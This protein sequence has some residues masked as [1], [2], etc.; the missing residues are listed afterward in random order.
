MPR[1]EGYVVWELGLESLSHV[2]WHVPGGDEMRPLTEEQKNERLPHFRRGDK[3]AVLYGEGS[4]VVY[5]EPI[6]GRGT[7]W[8]ALKALDRGLERVV[9]VDDYRLRMRIY[10]RVAGFLRTK[11]RER[12]IEAYEGGRLRFMDLLGDSTGLT[13]P[14]RR[15]AGGVYVYGLDS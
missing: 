11:D 12:L 4:E 13:G 5:A 9:P 8:N 7:V 15:E 3:M 14:F 1:S 2:H 10:Q 6:H